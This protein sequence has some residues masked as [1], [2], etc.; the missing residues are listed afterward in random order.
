MDGHMQTN[1]LTPA[2]TAKSLCGDDVLLTK[3][4]LD[5]NGT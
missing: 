5:K 4:G 3:I 1:K 2:H